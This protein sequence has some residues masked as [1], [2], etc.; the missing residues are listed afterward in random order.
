MA[1]LGLWGQPATT[2]AWLLSGTAAVATAVTLTRAASAGVQH[3]IRRIQVT[4]SSANAATA[5]SAII[6]LDG[7]TVILQWE[8]TYAANTAG[9]AAPQG[10]FDIDLG[11][12]PTGNTVGNLLTVTTAAINTVV[13]AAPPASMSVAINVWG[14][15]TP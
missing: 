14:F 10:I 3:W 1:N 13:A 6:V 7:A 12:T 5:P 4:Y 2:N 9:S 11:A 15:S 8:F